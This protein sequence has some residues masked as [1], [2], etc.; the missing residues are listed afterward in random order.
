MIYFRVAIGL[1]WDWSRAC[2]EGSFQLRILLKLLAE[3]I[4]EAGLWG[5]LGSTIRE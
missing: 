1:F 5:S 3:E 2:H 4:L